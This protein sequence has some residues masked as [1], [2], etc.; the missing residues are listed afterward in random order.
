MRLQ[1][2]LLNHHQSAQRE[3]SSETAHLPLSKQSEEGD[4]TGQH[5][6]HMCA[7]IA[8]FS[9]VFL[10]AHG[11]DPTGKRYSGGVFTDGTHVLDKRRGS[12]GSSRESSGQF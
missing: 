8:R 5:I 10:K 6:V 9:H 7:T 11:W 1:L 3:A 12:L 2:A 4:T